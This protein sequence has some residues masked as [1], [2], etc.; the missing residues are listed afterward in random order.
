MKFII[1]KGKIS[2]LFPPYRVGGGGLSK[3][4]H[5]FVYH[6]KKYIVRKCKT[7]ERADS[8]EEIIEKLEKH[9]FLPKYLGRK[10]NNLFFEYIPGRDLTEEDTRYA[11]RIGKIYGYVNNEKSKRKKY[12]YAS[13]FKKSLNFLIEKRVIN[14]EKQDI[15]IK[16]F[17]QLHKNLKLKFGIDLL[18]TDPTNFRLSRGKIYY[19]DIE[20]FAFDIIGRGFGKVFLKWFKTEKQRSNFLDGYN[21]VYSSKY[22]TKDYLQFIYLFFLIRN[23]RS[24]IKNKLDYSKNLELLDKLLK[25]KLK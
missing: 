7:K 1:K 23:T 22:L 19:V 8:F 17:N 5:L 2:G 13:K 12:N 20:G 10:R 18:D 25:G 9:K 16:K 15:I 21:S 14:K 3:E 11:A 4:V 24:K 6:G